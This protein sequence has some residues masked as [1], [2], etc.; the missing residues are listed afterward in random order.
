MVKI[1]G[2]NAEIVSDNQRT[3]D[4]TPSIN[5]VLDRMDNNFKQRQVG[6]LNN[7]NQ[8]NAEQNFSNQ[9]IF[10]SGLISNLFP[11]FKQ[12][13]EHINN[14][15]TMS[16]Y[17][18]NQNLTSGFDNNFLMSILPLILSTNNKTKTK[19]FENPIFKELLK[20]VNNPIIQKIFE[21]LPKMKTTTE[22]QTENKKD[23]A[24]IDSYVKTSEYL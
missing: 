16:T 15:N 11:N 19:G 20:R 9:N 21:M 17:T 14:T 10:A 1:N 2:V 5:E 23:E 8:L 18:N 4:L 3:K 7:P 24:K 22:T 6:I 13:T 12:S